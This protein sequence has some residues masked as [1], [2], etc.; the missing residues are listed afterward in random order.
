MKKTLYCIVALTLLASC[1]K[2]VEI[3]DESKD[4]SRESFNELTLSTIARQTK[5][6]AEGTYVP[7]DNVIGFY[8]NFHS[9]LSSADFTSYNQIGM[10]GY[11]SRL[12]VWR[13][14]DRSNPLNRHSGD[15]TKAA[16]APIPEI[17]FDYNFSPVYWPAGD[18]VFMDYVAFS[19]SYMLPMMNG[20]LGN[21][22]KG[23]PLTVNPVS[24]N[25]NRMS[26]NYEYNM[27]ENGFF[28]VERPS[29]NYLGQLCQ[30]IPMVNKFGIQTGIDDNYLTEF[31][32][33]YLD[34]YNSATQKLYDGDDY[35]TAAES[36]TEDEIEALNRGYEL[37]VKCYPV[38]NKFMQDDLL[39]AHDRNLKNDNRGAVKATF[40]HSKAWVKVIV[41]NKTQNDIYVN[42]IRFN[43]VKSSGTLVIDNSKSQFE[44]YWN[45]TQPS[46]VIGASI[47]PYSA[48]DLGGSTPVNPGDKPDKPGDK[49]DKP[50]T[51]TDTP[52][53]I[54]DVYLVPSGCY[55]PAIS[56]SEVLV[57]SKVKGLKFNY[58]NGSKPFSISNQ[59]CSTMVGKLS[60]MMFPAQEPGVITISYNSWEHNSEEFT[61]N[62][63]GYILHQFDV[64]KLWKYNTNPDKEITL[65]LPRQTWQMGKVYVYVLTIGEDEITINPIVT[66]WQ[67]AAPI[68]YPDQPSQPEQPAGYDGGINKFGSNDTNAE[69]TWGLQ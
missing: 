11:D 17:P 68:V 18:R 31:S 54:P 42:D 22:G 3:A 47:S 43:D 6:V 10:F 34:L 19:Y 8:P 40:N 59:D 14:V 35:E 65:N 62:N 61:D 4:S 15:K 63:D 12:N 41:N 27:P 5:A 44:T 9:D 50:D 45:F 25:A 23:S 38:I 48:V 1:T 20:I 16:G 52:G 69:D 53:L 30:Y 66:D 67:V 60:G 37:Y 21:S 49:P 46:S 51:E 2:T 57:D 29:G 56:V 24:D 13:N 28:T 7:Y 26:V 58:L 33:K 36:L 55:G 39:Y 32:T 64:K